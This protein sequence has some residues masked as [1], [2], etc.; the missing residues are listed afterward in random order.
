ML[1]LTIRLVF[2]VSK[3]TTFQTT[4][5]SPARCGGFFFIIAPMSDIPDREVSIL[6]LKRNTGERGTRMFVAH[7]GLVYD[8]TDCS[9][10]RTGLHENQHFPGQELTDEL[11]NNAPHTEIVFRNPCVKIVGRLKNV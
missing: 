10:W 3:L 9:R 7:K 8:V 2:T 11:E 1:A 5:K 4:Q 6:E